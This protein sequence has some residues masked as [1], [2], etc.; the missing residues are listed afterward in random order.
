MADGSTSPSDA[1]TEQAARAALTRACQQVEISPEGAE[2]IRIGSNAV[3][4]L[5]DVIARVAPSTGL[6]ANAEKQIAVA[7]WLASIDY[8]AMRALDV[9]QPIEAAGRV[10]TFWHSVATE[11]KFAPMADVA[12][13]IRRLHSITS[14][15]PNLVLLEIQPFGPPGAPL[16]EFPGLPLADA[17]FLQERIF[18]GS[19][20]APHAAVRPAA[21]RHSR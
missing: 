1:F 11:T 8:P 6:F 3:F 10:V 14:I 4:R 17:R 2:L 9:P 19:R 5:G 16:P 12:T 7:R 13:L 15:P 21:R 20:H 18:L